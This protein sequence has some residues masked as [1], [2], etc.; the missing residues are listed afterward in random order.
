MK[1]FLLVVLGVFIGAIAGVGIATGLQAGACLTVEAA[2]SEGLITEAQ[3]DE[4]LRA[5][6][7]QLASTELPA[8]A[9]AEGGQM[10]CA[11]VVADLKAAVSE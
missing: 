1:S 2:V 11:K 10:D 7:A 5:A 9:A 6:A 4:A 3:V 8:A